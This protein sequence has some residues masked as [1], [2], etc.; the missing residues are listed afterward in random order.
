MS[1]EEHGER[2]GGTGQSRSPH[3]SRALRVARTLSFGLVVAWLL[4]CDASKSANIA[5]RKQLQRQQETIDRFTR[6]QAGYEA[7]RVAAS[8]PTS[9]PALTPQQTALLYTTH[10]LRFG[11]LTGF[12]D[13][14]LTVHLV[15]TDQDG[16][17]LKA[18]GAI[19]VEVF[20]LADAGR[21]LSRVTL[22]PGEAMKAWNG[23]GLR[24]EYVVP[25][26]LP[27]TPKRDLTVR[28]T[29]TDALTG[30]VFDAQQ[31]IKASTGTPE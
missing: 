3:V 14:G 7:D 31:V 12:D 19:T 13:G 15:P 11:R 25:C 5:L 26:P 21:R 24:Y 18:A 17:D 6:Q 2:K 1:H 23:T 9:G 8:R 4:G 22:G 20:D 16:D 30:R 29:F 27:A 10:G 28:A